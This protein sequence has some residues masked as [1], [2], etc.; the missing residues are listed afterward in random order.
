MVRSRARL[1]ITLTVQ[2]T[3]HFTRAGVALTNAVDSSIAHTPWKKR[4]E[5]KE[6]A[7]MGERSQTE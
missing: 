3:A 5:I 2:Q 1:Q 6:E 4:K 7:E